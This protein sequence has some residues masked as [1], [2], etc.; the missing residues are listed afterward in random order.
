MATIGLVVQCVRP[1]ISSP[2][3]RDAIRLADVGCPAFRGIVGRRAQKARALA[4]VGDFG[5]GKSCLS[6][7]SSARRAASTLR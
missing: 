7:S 4:E 6:T 5:G 3:V 1:T 2:T